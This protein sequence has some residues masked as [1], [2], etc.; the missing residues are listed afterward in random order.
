M[1]GA[2]H[3]ATCERPSLRDTGGVRHATAYCVVSQG[4][5][6]GADDGRTLQL[7]LPD[8]RAKVGGAAH[9]K[10]T[11]QR[12]FLQ[13]GGHHERQRDWPMAP[14]VKKAKTKPIELINT[15]NLKHNVGVLGFL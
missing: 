6:H 2:A 3:E 13:H 14:P 1:G 11:A 8:G 12:R 4:A 15:N 5:T 7:L 9:P 10:G